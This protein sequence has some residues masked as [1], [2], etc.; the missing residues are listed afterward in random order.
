MKC[1][2]RRQQ[3]SIFVFFSHICQIRALLHAVVAFDVK[4][5]HPLNLLQ[6]ISYIFLWES[7]RGKIYSINTFDFSRARQGKYF[8]IIEFFRSLLS[9]IFRILVQSDIFISSN[10]RMSHKFGAVFV[11]GKEKI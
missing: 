6:D 5:L 1:V 7:S 10:Q 4:I 8:K 3:S 9:T 11:C 2:T